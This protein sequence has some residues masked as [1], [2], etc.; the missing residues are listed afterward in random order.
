MCEAFVALP[1]HV[2]ALSISIWVKFGLNVTQTATLWSTAKGIWFGDGFAPTHRL[3][4]FVSL[5][6]LSALPVPQVERDW[7]DAEEFGGNN[8]AQHNPFVGDENMFQVR[9]FMGVQEVYDC[10]CQ[11]SMQTWY[12]GI[13]ELKRVT[14]AL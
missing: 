5:T 1:F 6:L 12:G 4:V 2:K 10:E 3:R 7:Y 11:V 9:G 14:H 8:D 13:D